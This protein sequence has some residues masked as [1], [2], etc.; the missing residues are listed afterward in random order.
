MA[1]TIEFVSNYQDLCTS[2]GFQFEFTCDRCGTGYRTE[3]KTSVTGTASN[4]LDKV[5]SLF[6]GVLRSAADF[7]QDARSAAWQKARDE[8][9]AEAVEKIRPEFF[10]CPRCQAWVC[11]KRCLNTRKGLCKECAPDLGVEMAAAQSSRSV[12]EV[13]AHAAMAEEDKQLG[14]ENWRE[15]IHASCPECEAPLETNAKFC[16]ACGAEVKK[17]R[18]CS[19]CGGKLTP[20]AKFCP[21]CGA[22][23]EEA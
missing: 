5:G 19:Q 18:F 11:R 6:G 20:S 2:N 21:Q 12:E 4:L 10:Q 23:S 1:K 7:T 15:T 3:F 17:A 16:A 9:F 13:W 22:K 8:A 14:Q